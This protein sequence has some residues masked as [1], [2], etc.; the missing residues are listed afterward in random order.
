MDGLEREVEMASAA[1]A[2]LVKM[3]ESLPETTQNQVVE[4]L[5]DYV[6]E[7]RDERRWDASF[8]R[9]EK[10]LAALAQSARR[11]IAQGQAAPLDYAR[12]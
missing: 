2:T 9:T 10:P 7:M 5:R 4:H 12:L 11:E 3:I 6:A 8:K 1:I